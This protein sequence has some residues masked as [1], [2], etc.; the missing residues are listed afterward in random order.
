MSVCMSVCVSVSS[1]EKLHVMHIS[2]ACI[3]I[4]SLRSVWM[5]VCVGRC[6]FITCYICISCPNKS[7]TTLQY[8]IFYLVW[9]NLYCLYSSSIDR[10]IVAYYSSRPDR[11]RHRCRGKRM[12]GWIDIHSVQ[13]LERHTE[14]KKQTMNGQTNAPMEK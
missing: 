2:T 13:E 8:R 14:M 7:H 1:G 11:G 12:N 5:R 9:Q 6:V 10:H 4:L 3:H